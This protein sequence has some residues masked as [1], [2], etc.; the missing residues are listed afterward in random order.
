MEKREKV[1]AVIATLMNLFAEKGELKGFADWDRFIGCIM[2]LQ[3]V[4]D[5]LEAEEHVAQMRTEEQ[6]NGEL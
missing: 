1:N 4:A 3:S 2:T 5:M 6:G